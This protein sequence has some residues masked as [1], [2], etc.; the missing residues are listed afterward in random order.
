M[1]VR[2]RA[3]YR[4]V[5]IPEAFWRYL[6]M[7]R[8]MFEAGPRDGL[9]FWRDWLKREDDCRYVGHMVGK[10]L[11]QQIEGGLLAAERENERLRDR[12][13]D[14][15]GFRA[16]LVKQGF[17]PDDLQYRWRRQMECMREGLPARM[18]S[19]CVEKMRAVLEAMAQGD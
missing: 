8:G 16:E 10:A 13:E 2:R 17:N 14:M 7:C 11:R 3:A 18:L 6:V 1:R 12:L 4:D 19:E 15:E 9:E 5:V